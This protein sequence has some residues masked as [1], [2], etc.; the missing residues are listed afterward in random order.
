MSK[1]V[2]MDS[3]DWDE[4]KKRYPNP[5]DIKKAVI[6]VLQNGHG[7]GNWRRLITNLLETL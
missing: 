5:Y 2:P 7:G 1:G 3:G 6:K 4:F